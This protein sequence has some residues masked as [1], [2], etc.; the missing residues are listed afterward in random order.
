MSN[1]KEQIKFPKVNFSDEYSYPVFLEDLKKIGFEFI[2]IPVDDNYLLATLP[3][4]WE[5]K[6]VNEDYY[7]LLDNNG[8]VR[9]NTEFISN[10]DEHHNS[11]EK[12]PAI[13]WRTRYYI[14]VISF[15]DGAGKVVFGNSNEELYSFPL[16]ANYGLSGIASLNVEDWAKKNYPNWRNISSYWDINLEKTHQ[17]SLGTQKTDK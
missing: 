11:N 5:F 12:C 15:E 9:A 2:D 8:F 10:S 6:Q 7:E 4:G 14:T 16:F 17:K 13:H 3:E 1:N